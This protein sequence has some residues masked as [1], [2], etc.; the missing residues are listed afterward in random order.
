M[1]D[2]KSVLPLRFVPPWLTSRHK[3]LGVVANDSNL[4]ILFSEFVCSH[5]IVLP[6]KQFCATQFSVSVA[7]W[8]YNFITVQL[9]LRHA[10]YCCR[11][12]VCLFVRPSVSLSYTCIVTKQNNR[13]SVSEDH[14]QQGYL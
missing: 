3:H 10:R 14:M 8:Q 4:V 7:A 2:C 5:Y 9:K 11:N 12:S 6:S 1:Q 13:L